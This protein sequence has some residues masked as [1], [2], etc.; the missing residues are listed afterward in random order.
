[1]MTSGRINTLN[2]MDA[3]E[4]IGKAWIALDEGGILLL[5]PCSYRA[6]E[7]Q[8]TAGPTWSAG[9]DGLFSDGPHICLGENCWNGINHTLTKRWYIVDTSTAQ[10]RY[11]A[12]CRQAYHRGRLKHLLEQRDFGDIHFF[13]SL[14]GAKATPD[15]DYMVVHAVKQVE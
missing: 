13:P 10:V 3:H 5:E 2:P 8:G 11:L 7:K 4:F 9:G 15:D 1:M 14:T 12:Q 6:L